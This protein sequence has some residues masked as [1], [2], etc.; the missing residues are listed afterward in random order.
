MARFGEINAQYFDD[1]GDPL[2]SGK[3]YFYESGTTTPKVTYADINLT[4][5]NT[6]PVILTAAGR[7]PNIFFN[8]N[9][10]GILTDKNDVQILV[11]DPI[12]ETGANFGDAWVATKIYS[13]N[14][15]VIGSDGVYYRS[16]ANG[17]QNNNPTT[18]SGFWTLLYSVEWNAGITYSAGDVVTYGS[19][20]YQSLQDSN[21]NQNPSTVTA[22]WA[23]LAFAWLATRTYAI[24]EN[25]VGTDGILYTSLQNS[26]TGN[27]PASS[28]AY[29]VGTSAAAA[30]S[31]TAAA[32]SA[33][34]AATSATA[35]ATS[36][37]DSANS[38]TASASSATAAAASASTATT[39]A[40]EAATSATAAA[41][42]ATASAS[43]AT[44]AAGS[45]TSA[46]NK[47]LEFDAIYLGEKSSDP[48]VDNQG[49]ALQEGA[50]Y[51]NTTTDL[52]RVYTGSA[53]ANVAPTATSIDLA[54]QVTGVLPIANGGTNLSALGSAGQV[55]TVNSAGNALEYTSDSGGSVTSVGGTGTVNGISLSGTVTTSG[56][57]TLG[58]ALTGVDLTSQ[59]TGT[60]PVANGGTGATTLTANNVLLGNGTSAP[61][62]VAPST[63][64]NVLTSNGST[65]QSTAPAGGGLSVDFV[66]SGALSSGQTVVL[67]TDGTV[68]AVGSTTVS[69]DA[70]IGSRTLVDGNNTEY[71]SIAA[72]P[73][74]ENRWAAV[75]Q[76]DIG[77]KDMFM[78]VFTRS[79]TSITQS[80]AISLVTGGTANRSCEVCFDRAQENVV[81]LMYND[82]T[83][84]GV[85]QVATISG[86]AGSESVALGTAT[87]FYTSNPIFTASS[88]SCI[89]LIC[90]DT[91]GNF[92]GAWVDANASDGTIQG[93]I[94]Q[95]SGTSVTA[96]GSNTNLA[97][98][99]ASYAESTREICRHY[100]D[101]T[102]AYLAYKDNGSGLLAMKVLTVSGT[103]I[104]VGTTYKNTT[105]I[106]S[107]GV[108]ISPVSATKLIVSTAI[109]SGDYPSYHVVTDSSGALSYG[110]YTVVSSVNSATVI[111][112]GNQESTGLVFPYYYD[113][114]SG[115]GSKPFVKILT[116]NSDASTI[117]F[118]AEDQI[119]TNTV[120]PSFNNY[121]VQKD[122][123]NH[124]L[125]LAEFSDDLYYILGKA[126]GTSTNSADFIGITDAAISDTATG[127]V[128]VK[129]GISTNVSS[130]TIGTDYYVQDDGTLATTVSSV[131]AGK[132]L[133][134]TSILLQGL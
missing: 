21:L 97:T 6:N 88:K 126:G 78:K 45:A 124:Y 107:N 27:V 50:I 105:D 59:I 84:D 95:V 28:G 134:S 74:N 63:A 48:T 96:G 66:A 125:F 60:L 31:A 20:Q 119:D 121:A 94:F 133:S 56:N 79:G 55:L 100:S 113:Y 13:A 70:P 11:R 89:N 110:T 51:F 77:N 12:G 18:T 81:L 112:R 120:A 34:A 98:D 2:G 43:S 15:V 69:P 108:S 130:L 52:M 75:Y 102:K 115:S 122:S 19:T 82:N 44:A 4:I 42:S 117:T 128:T 99:A 7:Q 92:M 123:S 30:A 64:G 53:W 103:S 1:A 87:D 61:Q 80:S 38:A 57:L 47:F 118:S 111:A 90:L 127:S 24:H 9:A 83:N 37:T 3:L 72:D 114:N 91:S 14:A 41:T 76:D 109:N 58:G 71:L 8:G 104:S 23:S 22:Y 26:N 85:V 101:A 86:S 46:N 25:V 33:T 73:F 35:A 93:R 49:S 62:A 39:K 67:K 116:S 16:L 29:W 68:E 17:N 5:P 129:G 10:K 65:W 32:T 40:G 106:D 131:P 36:A 132:A 54:S